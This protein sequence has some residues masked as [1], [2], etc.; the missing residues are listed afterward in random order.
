M[1]LVGQWPGPIAIPG[2]SP[3]SPLP[4]QPPPLGPED[5]RHW[6]ARG[7]DLTGDPLRPGT[8][9]A[10]PVGGSATTRRL[11]PQPLGAP[12][13]GEGPQGPG[14]GERMTPGRRGLGIT[15][16]AADSLGARSF[17][18]LVETRDVS[19]LIDPGVRLG[20]FR[21]GHRP[22]PREWARMEE[23]RRRIEG[24]ARGADVLVI[25][26]YHRD[27]FENRR[28]GIYRGKRLI[29]K[30]PEEHINHNQEV[31]AAGLLKGLGGRAEVEY[32]DGRTFTFGR[33]ELIFSRAQRHG[34]SDDLGWV[35][36]VAVRRGR[37]GF[38]YT[39]DIQGPCRPDHLR[40][41]RA[42]RPQT[43]FLD[44][45]PTYLA[46]EYGEEN[47]RRAREL[48]VRMLREVGA[49]L[50]VLDHHLL[51]DAQWASWVEPLEAVAR[52]EGVRLT[53]VAGYLGREPD[54]LEARRSQLYAEEP[55]DEEGEGE[56][57]SREGGI[58]GPD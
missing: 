11:A 56:E 2:T 24:A 40:F 55:H 29:V 50:V 7:Q 30:H 23:L 45:P 39:S 13:D 20:P 34:P 31:R 47:L 42:V 9:G 54:L 35:V 53:T 27:H 41:M 4:P 33:T 5:G 10:G 46:E 17:A 18:T 15:P 38:L 51:R 57:P 43:I 22:H 25:T 14:L 48:S 26:H 52:E 19:I 58:G 36:Q 16:I 21:D 8:W 49:E 37:E 44:G 12:A 32:A 6:G 1:D 28:L 3:R